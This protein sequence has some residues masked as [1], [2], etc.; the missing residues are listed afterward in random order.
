MRHSVVEEA[1]SAPRSE[2]NYKLLTMRCSMLNLL[3]NNEIE[4]S[5]WRRTFRGL[6][7]EGA[8]V[9][10]LRSSIRIIR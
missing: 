5:R 2:R 1:A 7:S 3:P 10:E 6:Y 9:P 8:S 4:C